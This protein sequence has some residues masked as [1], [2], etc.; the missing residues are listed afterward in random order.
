MV[1]A[2][3]DLAGWLATPA[4][5]HLIDKQQA[6]C[7][8]HLAGLGGYRLAQLGISPECG[9]LDN[10]DQLHKFSLF[11][12]S[13]PG[14]SAICDFDALPL[15][16]ESIDIVLLHHALDFSPNPH[17]VLK[18]AARVVIPGGHIVL[19]GF[20]PLSWTGIAKWAAIFLSDHMIWRHHSLRAVRVTDWLQLLGFQPLPLQSAWRTRADSQA[21]SDGDWPRKLLPAGFRPNWGR[22]YLIVARKQVAR[23]T[24][25][26]QGGWSPIRA[27][28]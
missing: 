5:R 8:E 12:E 1:A 17:Q 21:S 9:L 4:G 14:I 2:R 19:F 3:E 6:S 13:T 22:F 16:A 26:K 27:S 11:P 25:I 10:F 24:P 20:N 23:L 28:A 15:P 18:E 7:R